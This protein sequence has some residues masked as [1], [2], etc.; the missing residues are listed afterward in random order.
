[1]ESK[2]GYGSK[3]TFRMKVFKTND[4]PS[5]PQGS[6]ELK[7]EHNLENTT[8]INIDDIEIEQA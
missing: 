7:P 8:G 6:R 4:A 5:N 2:L 1:M 3:F